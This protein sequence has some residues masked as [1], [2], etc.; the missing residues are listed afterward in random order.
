MYFESH[1]KA[2]RHFGIAINDISVSQDHLQNQQCI[3]LHWGKNSD[4]IV[5]GVSPFSVYLAR[6][7]KGRDWQNV[8]L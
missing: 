7:E 2:L 1:S 8:T 6:N 5:E 3:F 4:D